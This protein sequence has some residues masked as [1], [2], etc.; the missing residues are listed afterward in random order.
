[1]LLV[2]SHA[3]LDMD[4]FREDLPAVLARSHAAGVRA[5]VCPSTHRDTFARNREI[6][7]AHPECY[8]FG[9]IHPH[10]AKS[11]SPAVEAEL[12]A[13]LAS[14][15]MYAVGEIGLDYHYDFSP[16]EVQ[17]EVF[18]REIALSREL[19]LPIVIHLRE[20]VEDLLSILHEERD[21]DYDG[22]VHC[23]SEDAQAAQ[24]LLGLGFHL[25]VTGN[26]SFKKL[27]PLREVLRDVPPERVFIETDSPY[28]TPEPYRGRRCEP[29]LVCRV[30]ETLAEVW[31]MPLHEVCRRTSENAVRLFRLPVALPR[32]RNIA[33]YERTL[34]VQV[35][36][37]SPFSPTVCPRWGSA[38]SVA[39]VGP[40]GELPEVLEFTEALD[41]FAGDTV[42]IGSFGEVLDEAAFVEMLLGMV[43][44]RGLRTRLL[45]TG[46]QVLPAG[47]ALLCD[48]L[49][50]PVNGASRERYLGTLQPSSGAAAWDA[51]QEVARSCRR[52]GVQL[53]GTVLRQPKMSLEA[54]EAFVTGSLG[55]RIEVLDLG[56]G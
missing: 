10:D 7:A 48:E 25:S 43:K 52:Q 20:A 56:V 55:G 15:R 30:A 2:E 3:H 49:V 26:V 13:H 40:T 37:E 1:M 33:V 11:W 29:H 21:G 5:I 47:V 22:V 4:V 32:P 45:G 27:E 46:Q 34:A 39:L 14:P 50:V 17:R 54:C 31:Q 44:A 28:M 35:P 9:G 42:E 19:G 38:W 12:R 24:A 16:R 8:G 23:F 53:V 18:R 51:L 41:G 6:L 36:G